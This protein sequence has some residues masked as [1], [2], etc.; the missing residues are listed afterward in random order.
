ME[1]VHG[2]TDLTSNGELEDLR[3]VAL[4]ERGTLDLPIATQYVIGELEGWLKDPA[5]PV[6]YLRSTRSGPRVE[7]L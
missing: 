4:S 1:H 5:R 7:T 2:T 3:W 6:R